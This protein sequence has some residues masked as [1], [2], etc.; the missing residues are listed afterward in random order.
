MMRALCDSHSF[1]KALYQIE[2][3]L[4]NSGWFLQNVIV[5][6][7]TGIILLVQWTRW[8]DLSSN[9]YNHTFYPRSRTLWMQFRIKPFERKLICKLDLLITNQFR[10]MAAVHS[11][12][13]VRCYIDKS[14]IMMTTKHGLPFLTLKHRETHGCVVSTV[15][16]DVLVLK[17]QAISIHNAD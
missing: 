1:G 11:W 14:Y 6:C 15:T 4:V 9:T 17:H 8:G 7:D 3:I 12:N 2:F 5:V 16:T 13:C 10:Q